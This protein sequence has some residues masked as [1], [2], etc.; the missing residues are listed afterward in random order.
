MK[1]QDFINRER[2]VEAL[3]EYQK[4]PEAVRRDKSMLILRMRAA[5][6]VSSEEYAACIEDFR[7]YHPN[8][9]ALDFLLVGHYSLRKEYAEALKCLDRV[10][11]NVGGDSML[12][13]QRAN[14]LA[15]LEKF[16]EARKAI[17]DAIAAEPD[18]SDP[19]MAGLDVSVVAKEFDDT[20]KYLNILEKRSEFNGRTCGKCLLFKSSSS[21]PNI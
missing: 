19:Y 9:A 2:P 11:L 3:E 13:A 20:V 1:F 16:D 8:D 5:Q 12:L 6:M 10:N 4:F 17:Q 7:K 15:L 18:V 14:L 21:R